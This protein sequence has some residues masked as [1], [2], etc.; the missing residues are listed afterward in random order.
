[1]INNQM[2]DYNY[3]TL[4]ETDDYGQRIIDNEP[5]GSIKMAINL[6]SHTIGQTPLYDN[7]TYIGLTREPINDS[8]IIY[9]EDVKLKVQ[10]VNKFG[11]LNQVFMGILK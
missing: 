5:Q 9:F 10:F 4:N 3:T 11:N 8:Y 6:I 1:M 7:S 2:R